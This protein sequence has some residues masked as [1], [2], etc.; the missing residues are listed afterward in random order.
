MDMTKL[1]NIST[2]IEQVVKHLRGGA[3][4][5]KRRMSLDKFV[6]YALA[7]ITKA[8]DDEPGL[9]K[10]RLAALKRSVDGVIATLAKMSAEDTESESIKVDVETAFAPTKADGD[11]P[12]ADLTTAADQSSTETAVAQLA[13][14]TGDT[15]FTKNLKA[16]AKA[17][18]KM[19]ADLESEAG[20]KPA[21]PAK[22][23]D[24]TR[25]GGTDAAGGEAAG[26]DG[27]A[28]DGERPADGWP[29]DLNTAAFLTGDRDADTIL[30]WGTDPD[31][32]AS[33]TPR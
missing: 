10:R 6:R 33:P 25:A 15:M 12:M 21:K 5:T 4:T 7:Q 26:E 18:H 2:A 8:S 29:L 11:T 9:A 27:A 28:G 31:E 23:T 17:L 13:S 14:A 1:D 30:T 32:I 16:V 20:T 22:K 24:A 3:T 19:K